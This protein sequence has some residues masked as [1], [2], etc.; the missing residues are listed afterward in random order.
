MS[1]DKLKL[2]NSVG[3][4]LSN[5]EQDVQ[6]V[7][8]ELF[9]RGYFTKSVENGIIDGE[10]TKAIKDFQKDKKLK[11]DGLMN[12]NGETEQAIHSDLRYDLNDRARRNQILNNAHDFKFEV[13]PSEAHNGTF[14]FVES[15]FK[16]V[17]EKP[18]KSQ[19][20]RYGH[21]IDEHSQRMGVDSDI[22]KSIMHIENVRGYYDKKMAE[23]DKDESIQPMNIRPSLWGKLNNFE[24]HDFRIPYK[25]I[26]AGTTLI[27]EISDRVPDKDIAKIG[28]LYQNLGAE[29]VSQYGQRVKEIYDEKPWNKK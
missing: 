15:S 3:N 22:V 14:D 27:K 6:N 12:P 1:D 4:N 2:S 13:K 17:F 29:S 26:E 24:R 8:R 11:V 5:H 28:T 18:E 9:K 7:K 10:V 21:I 16:R 20:Q 25:N 23:L 19:V